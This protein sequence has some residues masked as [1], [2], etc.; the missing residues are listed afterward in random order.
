MAREAGDPVSSGTVNAGAPFDLVATA[1]AEHSTYAGIVRLVEEAQSSKAPFVRLA[2][3]Y[4]LLFVPLTLVIAGYAWMMLGGPGACP[5][6]AGRGDA[7]PA[8]PGRAHRHRRRHQ[9]VRRSAGS[10]S[11]AVAPWRPSPGHAS[12]CSTRPARSPQAG[13]T[14]PT[15]R[16]RR[17]ARRRRCC[18]S[19]AR[20][21]RSRRTSSR[22][23][24]CP[25]PASAVST[26][27]LP[28]EAE[29]VPGAGITGRVDGQRGHV[30]TA[31]FA[32]DGAPLPAWARDVRRR[33]NLEGATDVYVGVDGRAG[34]RTRAGRS[35]PARD[36]AGDPLPAAGRCPAHGHGHRRPLRRGGHRRRRHRRGRGAGRADSQRQGGRGRAGEGRRRRGSS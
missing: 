13:R 23:R 15:S 33:V 28:E 1:T 2:D 17:T 6:R 20:W 3:R 11:R 5:V 19:P 30:G 4:A 36:A 7:L 14:S 8:A 21:S 10:S 12:S 27:A 26:L 25:A 22:R 32:T 31:D 9:S 18:A 16:R 29:E 24:S 34:R 35:D